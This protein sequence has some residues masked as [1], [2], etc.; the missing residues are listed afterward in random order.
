MKF[1]TII[2]YISEFWFTT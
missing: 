1:E 2:K